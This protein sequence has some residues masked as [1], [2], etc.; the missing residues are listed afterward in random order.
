MEDS[1]VTPPTSRR[2]RALCSTALQ[3]RHLRRAA[4]RAQAL[5]EALTTFWFHDL[6]EL[7]CDFIGINYYGREIISGV[8]IALLPTEEYSDAGRSVYPE[9]LFRVL[10]SFAARCQRSPLYITENGVADEADL[11]RSAYLVEHLLAVKA[12]IESSP[13]TVRTRDPRPQIARNPLIARLSP[14]AYSG[15]ACAGLRLLDDLRQLG[16]GRRL[17][18]QVWPRRGEP[19]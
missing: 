12:A 4:A 16:V 14:T 18:P 7:E 10:R 13:R 19:L 5:T 17:L 6:I 8:C 11:I 1:R 9:G 3:H 15:R 2:L